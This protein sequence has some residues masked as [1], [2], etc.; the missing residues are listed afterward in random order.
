MKSAVIIAL[1]LAVF[2][3]NTISCSDAEEQKV[4]RRFA[5]ASVKPSCVNRRCTINGHC[6]DCCRFP[7]VGLCSFKT[8]TCL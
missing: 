1:V 8:C 4:L 7:N 5:R 6:S 2:L 3:I